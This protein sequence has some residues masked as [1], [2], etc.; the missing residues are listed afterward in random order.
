MAVRA[1]AGR[2]GTRTT[3]G[4]CTAGTITSSWRRSAAAT[5]TGRGGTLL[6][7]D[8]RRVPGAG[9]PGVVRR[10]VVS[11]S[12]EDAHGDEPWVRRL[13]T[14]VPTL[15]AMERR[16]LGVCFGHQVLCRALGALVCEIPA[17]ARVLAYSEKT[18][19]EAFAVGE[20]LRAL[21]VQGHPGYTADTLHNLIDRLTAQNDIPRRVGE[22]ARRAVV[23]TGGPDR[24]FWTVLCKS[25]LGGGG[26]TNSCGRHT[27]T[28]VARREPVTTEVVASRAGGGGGG[29]FTGA[30]PM[31]QLACHDSIN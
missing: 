1:A 8:R 11:G 12:P 5:T 4:R 25:F 24:A 28:T 6:P 16:I 7:R 20:H 30:A 14:L 3:P 18:R 31:V 2:C 27:A 15:H 19:V 9:G 29:C 23:E 21:G 22:D 26:R 13:C 10:F 17:G